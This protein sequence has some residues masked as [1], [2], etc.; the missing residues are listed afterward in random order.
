MR[1]FLILSGGRRVSG[2]LIK[3][4]DEE[5]TLDIGQWKKSQ[6]IKIIRENCG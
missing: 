6:I 3:E 4:T 1:I 5:I 2:K